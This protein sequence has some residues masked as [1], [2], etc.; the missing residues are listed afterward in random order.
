MF[1]EVGAP[2]GV[3]IILIYLTVFIDAFN[4]IAVF[5]KKKVDRAEYCRF[6]VRWTRV[7]MCAIFSLFILYLLVTQAVSAYIMWIEL[8]L[9]ILLL[10][11]TGLCIFMKIK[12]RK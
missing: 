12:Y 8:I 10:V 5:L 11:D 1:E 9:L 3:F 7:V 2:F 4:F 6:G